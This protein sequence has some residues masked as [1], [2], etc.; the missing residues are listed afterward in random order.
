[1]RLWHTLL[2]QHLQS[3]VRPL[4]DIIAV[5]KDAIGILK[6]IDAVAKLKDGK[7]EPPSYYLGALLQQKTIDG[8]QLWTVSS[9]KYIQAVIE[10]VELALQKQA[11]KLT[12]NAYMPMAASFIPELDTLDEL[13]TNDAQYYLK[14]IGILQWITELGRVNILH[15]VAILS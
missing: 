11:Y 5:S 9:Q 8:K 14:L 2:G 13:D 10:Q 15:K 6:S 1:M 12:K 3:F 7:I 4:H